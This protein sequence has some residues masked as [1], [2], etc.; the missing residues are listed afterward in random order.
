MRPPEHG[1]LCL[2]A[3]PPTHHCPRR[4]RG[5]RRQRGRR[6]A[7]SQRA[8]SQ[9][10]RPCARQRLRGREPI[11]SYQ[12]V[13]AR[14]HLW[15]REGAVV[16]TCMRGE[17]RYRSRPHRESRSARPLALVAVQRGMPPPTAS[18]EAAPAV[19]TCSAAVKTC[20]SCEAQCSPTPRRPDEPATWRR[21]TRW[22]EGDSIG[23]EARHTKHLWGNGAVVSTC[24]QGGATCASRIAFPPSVQPPLP[25]LPP[26]SPWPP[27]SSSSR[28]LRA[29]ATSAL[30]I[31]LGGAAEGS[32]SA[33]SSHAARAPV[34]K[35]RRSEHLHARLEECEDAEHAAYPRDPHKSH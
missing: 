16:S 14:P 10:R 19:K 26:W 20:R 25:P 23:S 18:S 15:G 11:E 32:R 34:G 1:G 13:R 7:D 29:A 6:R 3:A 24:M 21:P 17:S 31:P 30:T 12:G 22:G 4:R 2:G 9:P 35:W 8:Y 27:S 33:K 5:G 28:V